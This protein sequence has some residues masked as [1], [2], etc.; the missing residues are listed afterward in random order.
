MTERL[1][2]FL[3]T[4]ALETSCE[5]ATRISKNM[6]IKVSGDTI[7][8]ILLKKYDAMEPTTCISTVGHR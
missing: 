8:K 1:Y 5:S 3:C 7:I 4:L 6:N 2:D